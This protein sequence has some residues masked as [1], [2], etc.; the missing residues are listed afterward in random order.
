MSFEVERPPVGGL[1]LCF[2]VCGL[3]EFCLQ[4]FEDCLVKLVNFD[5]LWRLTCLLC[6]LCGGHF[7]GDRVGDGAAFVLG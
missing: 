6:S 7:L 4:F 2:G 5:D 1:F 3:D